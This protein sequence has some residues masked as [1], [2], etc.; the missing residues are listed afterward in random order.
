MYAPWCQ[1]C[2]AM[3]DNYSKLAGA[4]G[5]PTY[6]FRGDEQREFVKAEMNTASFPTINYMT[7]SGRL[8]KYASEDRSVKA[9]AA[10]AMEYKS[11][12]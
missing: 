4:S 8:I 5:L 7:A 6:K 2:Q 10:F 11:A 3:E 1:F 12:D 9:M